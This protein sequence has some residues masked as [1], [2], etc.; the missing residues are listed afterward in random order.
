MQRHPNAGKAPL[1]MPVPPVIEA[2]VC[3]NCEHHAYDLAS[4]KV[5]CMHPNVRIAD[6]TDGTWRGV[7]AD[8]VRKAGTLAPSG[9][10]GPSGKIYTPL[11]GKQE[12]PAPPAP[13]ETRPPYSSG[14]VSFCRG[15]ASGS[16]T[17]LYRVAVGD[18]DLKDET[19]MNTLVIGGKGHTYTIEK[20]EKLALRY[21]AHNPGVMARAQM[22]DGPKI[23]PCVLQRQNG[24]YVSFTGASFTAWT[25]RKDAAK[26]LSDL[27]EAWRAVDALGREGDEQA[28]RLI[29][30]DF[31]A[32]AD[33]GN[34]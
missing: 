18:F 26:V 16:Y 32:G 25:P 19:S 17:P 13:Q 6:V 28:V 15:R 27:R 11:K 10:C 24:D 3:I 23:R 7:S 34:A 22:T 1:L 9:L 20:A 21:M 31:S 5:L 2:P 33:D 8:R 4:A 12:P 29:E 14:T 30:I